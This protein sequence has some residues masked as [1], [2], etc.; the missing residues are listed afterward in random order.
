MSLTLIPENI[1]QVLK[2][3]LHDLVAPSSLQL[4]DVL[5]VG[6]PVQVTSSLV[7]EPV[8]QLLPVDLQEV[9]E[10]HLVKNLTA[11]QHLVQ[12]GTRTDVH[13]Q[14]TTNIAWRGRTQREER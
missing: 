14:L 5:Q 8:P 1:S 7:L 4:A 3:S 2:Q 10:E 12:G 6:C 11:T 13:Q 9:C